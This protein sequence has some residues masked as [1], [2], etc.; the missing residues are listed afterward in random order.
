M[1]RYKSNAWAF[2]E[3]PTKTFHRKLF[4]TTTFDKEMFTNGYHE[5]HM[6]ARSYFGSRDNFIE[7]NLPEEAD[8]WKKLSDFLGT[9]KPSI[10]FPHHKDYRFELI[11]RIAVWLEDKKYNNSDQ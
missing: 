4:G 5:F 2:N 6:K 11:D 8:P 9:E 1:F 10:P 7:V 3:E